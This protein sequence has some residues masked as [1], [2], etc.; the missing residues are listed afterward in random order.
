LN[1]ASRGVK[2]S[3]K[4]IQVIHYLYACKPHQRSTNM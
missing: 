4:L 1:D 3:E 2:W